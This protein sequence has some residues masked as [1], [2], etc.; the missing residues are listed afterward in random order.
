M[1]GDNRQ[2]FTT[3]KQI[4]LASKSGYQRLILDCFL[5][6]CVTISRMK[7]RS[8]LLSFRHTDDIRK[9]I[10]RY[11]TKYVK[12][13]FLLIKN[14]SFHLTIISKSETTPNLKHIYIDH[15]ACVALTRAKQVLWIISGPL[16]KMFTEH[17]RDDQANKIAVLKPK[18]RKS[19]YAILTLRN[20]MYKDDHCVIIEVTSFSWILPIEY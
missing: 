5:L 12:I 4:S 13:Q 6:A 3:P 17:R 1:D 11:T 14:L 16:E 2:N 20:D 18:I 19:L 8:V 7:C 9:N 15:H 10:W